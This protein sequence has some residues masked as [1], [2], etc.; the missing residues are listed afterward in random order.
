MKKASP[1]HVKWAYRLG[2]IAQGLVLGGLLAI[3]LFNLWAE[4]G[5]ARLFRYQN[6]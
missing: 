3:A 1:D 2:V 4:V 6:F 5:D